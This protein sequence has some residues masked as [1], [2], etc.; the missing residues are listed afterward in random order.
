MFVVGLQN[1]AMR[2]FSPGSALLAVGWLAA[3]ASRAGT[4]AAARRL[5]ADHF[6]ATRPAARRRQDARQLAARLQ[7]APRPL[8]IDR[9]AGWP[10][11]DSDGVSHWLP[12]APRRNLPGSVWLPNVSHGGPE[13]A[14]WPTGLPASWRG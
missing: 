2:Q 9:A 11:T 3:P 10:L 5:P 8:L 12:N 14:A 4:A 7:T 6:T 13:P 1:I